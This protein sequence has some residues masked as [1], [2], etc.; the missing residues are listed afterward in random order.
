[1]IALIFDRTPQC[2]FRDIELQEEQQN[3]RLWHFTVVWVY[4]SALWAQC[5]G[6][7]FL[8]PRFWGATSMRTKIF[9]VSS[10]WC[11][12]FQDS[13]CLQDG[14]SKGSAIIARVC[15]LLDHCL[16]SLHTGENANKFLRRL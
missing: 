6:S 8:S 13:A 5:A 12:I 10:G 11:L 7:I 15:V 1:M 3:G 9:N 14:E 4:L 2:I 16:A